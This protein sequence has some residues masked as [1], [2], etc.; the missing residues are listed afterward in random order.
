METVS[1]RPER[2]PW[3]RLRGPPGDEWGA[4]GTC[5]M[6]DLTLEKRKWE[7]MSSATVST[8]EKRRET[9]VTLFDGW[10]GNRQRHG[11]VGTVGA[12]PSPTNAFHSGTAMLTATYLHARSMLGQTWE[13]G[14]K[15]AVWIL[16]TAGTCSC[17]LAGWSIP[18]GHI[19]AAQSL[20]AAHQGET[21]GLAAQKGQ[22][23]LWCVVGGLDA[24]KL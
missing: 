10:V 6:L 16:P 14:K 2:G 11:S 20:V 1:S 21:A 5:S 8:T 17:C 22:L 15:Q 4:V 24:E 18:S 23:G 19:A 7:C 9:Y 3:N 13:F 12:N